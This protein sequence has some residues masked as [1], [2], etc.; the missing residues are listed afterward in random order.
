MQEEHRMVSE[1]EKIAVVTD[2]CGDVPKAFLEAHDNIFVLPLKIQYQDRT[3]HDGVDITANEVYERLPREIPKTSL[4]DGETILAI[5]DQ[6]R[7]QG[8]E[9]VIVL[10]FSS[11]LSGTFQFVKLLAQDYQGLDIRTYDTLSGSLGTGGIAMKVV[12]YVEKGR[13]F[14]EINALIPRLIQNTKV[15]FCIDTLEYLQKGGRIGLI[16][17]L[18]GTV[19]NIKPIISF[20]AD[21]QLVDVAKSRGRKQ[22][23]K[24]VAQLILQQI[25]PDKRYLL[26]FANGDAVEDMLAVEAMVTESLPDSVDIYESIIDSTLGVYVGPHLIGAGVILL[27]ED[28]L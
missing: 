27:D 10:I 20:S 14:E 6:I 22:S 23:L 26:M 25:V 4:P 28:M 21:G 13:S 2:S 11:G 1:G 19:L 3:Y 17:S 9:K 15:F 24:K 7:A 16:T 5:F 12:E 8:F 18:A